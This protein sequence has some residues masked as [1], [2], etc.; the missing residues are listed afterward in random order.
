MI[1]RRRSVLAGLVCAALVLCW[2]W[3]TVHANYEAR[4]NALFCTGAEL[5]QP[6]ELAAEHLYLFDGSQGYDGQMYH[7]VAH[8]PFFTRGF[9][10]Y[11]DAPRMRYRR[12]LV[13]LVAHV[14]AMGA[15]QRIDGA[16]FAVVLAAIFLGG[17]WLSLYCSML[18]W[19]AAW[20][21]AFLLVP[22]TLTSMDRLTVDAALAALCVAFALCV[23]RRSRWLLF[24][25]LVAAPL[26]RETGL[27]LIAAYVAWLASKK[28]LREAVRYASAAL[29]A[30]AW[31]EFVQFN[32]APDAF[33]GLSFLPFQGIAQRILTPYHYQFAAWIGAISTVLDY[34]A[35]AGIVVAIGLAVRM[36]FGREWGPLEL[37][38]YGFALLAMF[39]LSPGAWTEV[40]AFGRTL[41]PLLLF[42]GLRALVNRNWVYALPLALVVPRTAI[43]LAP[44]AS[45][46]LHHFL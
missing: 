26:V 3:L 40:Y 28:Q 33:A 1:S 13:P 4:W 36:A 27:V 19:S 32:T 14:L 10:G 12:I 45:G 29:P 39:L 34:L 35:L 8:D 5:K 7:Y 46:I 22:A 31:Y 20:G 25:V 9:D 37:S 41:T 6:P 23:A 16:Y 17:Y 18:G 24:A 44:Q 15:D 30:L 21:V 38:V 42:A 11:L 2:Q 43:Q